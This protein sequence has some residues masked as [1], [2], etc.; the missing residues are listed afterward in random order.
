LRDGWRHPCG[1]GVVAGRDDHPVSDTFELGPPLPYPG[2][3]LVDH[4]HARHERRSASGSVKLLNA[5]Q[6]RGGIVELVKQRQV[7]RRDPC[8]IDGPWSA[9][10]ED[11]PHKFLPNFVLAHLLFEAEEFLD[12]L[13]D[14]VALTALVQHSGHAFLTGDVSTAEIGH[15]DVPV[16]FEQRHQC[17]HLTEDAALFFGGDEGDEPAFVEGVLATTDRFYRV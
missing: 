6:P 10:V 1:L 15:D 8:V 9:E 11:A 17:L 7:L 16:S 14:T 4:E 5:C 12:L 13:A 2:P 3:G